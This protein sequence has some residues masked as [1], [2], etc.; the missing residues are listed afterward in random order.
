[1]TD[2]VK[3]KDVIRID[4]HKVKSSAKPG[5]VVGSRE[6]VRV[7]SESLRQVGLN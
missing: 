5:R 1:M 4:K 7:S 2:N 3:I 6:T